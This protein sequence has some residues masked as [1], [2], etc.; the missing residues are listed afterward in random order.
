[1]YKKSVYCIR[2]PGVMP[3]LES[4]PEEGWLFDSCGVLTHRQVKALTACRYYLSVSAPSQRT[5]GWR[6]MCL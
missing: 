1:M 2:K 6:L 3:S 5:G 4:T